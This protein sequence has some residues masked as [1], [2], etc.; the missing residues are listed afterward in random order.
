M[1][2]DSTVLLSRSKGTYFCD[3][4]FGGKGASGGWNHLPACSRPRQRLWGV[5]AIAR[6][7][8][9][10]A[11]CAVVIG[12]ALYAGPCLAQDSSQGAAPKPA[13]KSE[14]K[15]DSDGSGPFSA[16]AIAGVGYV[17]DYEGSNDYEFT[18]YFE[19]RINYK[20]YYAR[21][22]GNALRINVLPS[23]QFHLG[24][25]VSY[26]RGR[27]N[28]EDSRVDRMADIDGAAAVGG[29]IEYEHVHD[30]PRSAERVTLSASQAVGSA[31]GLTGTLLGVVRR[32]IDVIN[33]GLI[34]SVFADTSWADG[35]Y[36]KTY[37]GVDAADAARSGLPQFS[38]GSGLKDV[39]AG[40]SLD[41]FLSRT[42]SIGTRLH[43]SRLLSDAGD[44]PV[45][46]IAGSP[47]QFFVAVV[48][49][50]QFGGH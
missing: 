48:V 17:F 25:L 38:A 13:E 8:S 2:R 9:H 49:G 27:S 7:R 16:S 40:I 41:Q 36:M 46:D 33:R 45:T 44:S 19:A 20:D 26:R 3:K 32:P 11:A 12:L 28:V 6:I 1:C 37:F 43:Y 30:D 18:P 23:S 24:P 15:A 39:G 5:A 31:K 47:N 50:A 4:R 21:F 14:Q 29:F 10:G 22:E 34:A 35:E 42:W